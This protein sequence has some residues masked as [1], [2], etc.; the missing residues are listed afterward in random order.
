MASAI[1]TLTN[2]KRYGVIDIRVW[3]LLY[4]FGSVTDRASGIGL[5]FKHWYRYL[6]ILRHHARR[7]KTDVRAIERTLFFHHRRFARGRLY[8]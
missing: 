6:V 7:L 4:R 3:T 1:L 5:D 8:H 2:P